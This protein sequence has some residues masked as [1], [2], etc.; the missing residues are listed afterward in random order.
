MK[1][2]EI[3]YPIDGGDVTEILTEDE[4]IA[5][6]W[7]YWSGKMKEIGKEVD[8]TREKCIEDWCVIHW[9]V[10]VNVPI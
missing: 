1:L 4:I 7:K 6:Y 9:A 5:S 8:A 2:Y 10:E 3:A